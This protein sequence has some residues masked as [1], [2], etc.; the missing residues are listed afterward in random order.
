MS[1]STSSGWPAGLQGESVFVSSCRQV[2]SQPTL[3]KGGWGGGKGLHRKHV[4][5]QKI[6]RYTQKS[7]SFTV[8]TQAEQHFEESLS[9]HTERKNRK[10]LNYTC[11]RNIAHIN[12]LKKNLEKIK[13]R[14]AGV[15][16]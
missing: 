1:E 2:G 12:T 3:G 6:D 13:L 7:R 8:V 14:K 9:F 5:R 10:K 15:V 4:P 11:S 16:F